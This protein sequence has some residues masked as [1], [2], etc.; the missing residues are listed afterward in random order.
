MFKRQ[1][2]NKHV[3]FAFVTGEFTY[4]SKEGGYHVIQ[5]TFQEIQMLKYV[6]SIMYAQHI[7]IKI[8]FV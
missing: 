5:S 8:F 2:E 3:H 6:V 4:S 7:L 1:P